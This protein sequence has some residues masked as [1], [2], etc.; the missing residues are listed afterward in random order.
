MDAFSKTAGFIYIGLGRFAPEHVK[1]LRVNHTPR[2]G[3]V[4]A[5]FVSE[6]AVVGALASEEFNIADVA[7]TG[8]QLGAVCVGTGDQHS[9][10]TADVGCETRSNQLLHKF[11][12]GNQDFAAEV[13]AFLGG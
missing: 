2:N 11:L 7:V 5:S 13:S 4:E 8:E 3:C 6:E 12:R 9:R 1:V 10:N